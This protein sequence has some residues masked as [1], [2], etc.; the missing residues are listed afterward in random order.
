MSRYPTMDEFREVSRPYY[1]MYFTARRQ[2]WRIK[3]W[4]LSDKEICR[5]RRVLESCGSRWDPMLI[6][7]FPVV[8][9]DG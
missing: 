4:R 2:G 7:G 3:Q 1:E 9:R 6:L 5:V 8:R